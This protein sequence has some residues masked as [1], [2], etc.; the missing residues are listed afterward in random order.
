MLEESNIQHQMTQQIVSNIGDEVSDLRN[1]FNR[2]SMPMSQSQDDGYEGSDENNIRDESPEEDGVYI[3]GSLDQVI[4]E[5]H[6]S[7]EES[8]EYTCRS[9]EKTDPVVETFRSR[10]TFNQVICEEEPQ[11]IE[12]ENS[13]QNEKYINSS[14]MYI[15]QEM[16]TEFLKN[17]DNVQETT[18]DEI[19]EVEEGEGEGE[20]D[21]D[22]EYYFSCHERMVKDYKEV[23]KSW[24]DV[25]KDINRSELKDNFTMPELSRSTL[26]DQIDY[27]LM[28]FK[29]NES[30]LLDEEWDDAYVSNNKANLSTLRQNKQIC[31]DF[32]PKLIGFLNREKIIK[33]PVEEEKEPM[34]VNRA[35]RSNFYKDSDTGKYSYTRHSYFKLSLMTS[36]LDMF[37]VSHRPPAKYKWTSESSS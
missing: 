7:N 29:I 33:A 9:A 21:N 11:T 18:P 37:N 31:A 10:P 35:Y 22:L 36:S 27:D 28:D 23:N 20:G 1:D 12:Y 15:N 8:Q 14:Q 5:D 2:I 26:I 4:E 17:E 32:S 19:S 16:S 6:Y 24:G 3:Q 34:G 30:S 13:L 25:F